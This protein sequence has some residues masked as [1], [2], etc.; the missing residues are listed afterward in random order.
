MENLHFKIN[1]KAPAEKVWNIMLTD[2]TYRQWTDVFSPGSYYEG[3]WEKGEKIR[4]L[5]PDENGNVGGMVSIIAENRPYEF[6]SI[7]HLG[8]ITN[9]VEDTTSEEVQS[10]AGALENYT[11]TEVDGSTELAVDIIGTGNDEADKEM[12]EMFKDMW[13]K[14]L[15]KLKNLCEN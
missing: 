13:P 10:W 4:F 1:I 12:A 5:G 9:G 6:T 2:E 11:F 3:K 7:K 14:A 8:V 15:E